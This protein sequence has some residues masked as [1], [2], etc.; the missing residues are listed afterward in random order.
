V[1]VEQ[2]GG[3]GHS[4]PLLL[5]ARAL[6]RVRVGAAAIASAQTSLVVRWGSRAFPPRRGGGSPSPSL[7]TAAAVVARRRAR[8]AMG[9]N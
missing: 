3:G 6:M 8:A 4:R 1:W 7:L 9:D 2:E 5:L